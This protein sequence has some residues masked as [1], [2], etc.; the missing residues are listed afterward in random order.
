[1]P[2]VVGYVCLHYGLP[3]LQWA[4]RSVIDDL[5][6]LYVLYSPEGS[7]GHK[8]STPCPDKREDLLAAAQRGA[9][10][11]FEW[12]DAGTFAYEG[13]HRDTIFQVAPN[14]EI[15]VRL[16]YDEIYPTGLLKDILFQVEQTNA[17]RYR[18]PFI[19]FYRSFNTAILHDPAYPII[20][21]VPSRPDSEMTLQTRPVAHMGY[22]IPSELM[23]YKLSIHG[24]KNE[25]R[26]STDEYTASIYLNRERVTDLHP[27]G[28]DFWNIERVDPLD[29]M[30]HWMQD[31]PFYFKDVIE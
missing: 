8:S 20:V 23:R 12:I 9:G 16:D 11:K 24:H 1:M 3:Y 29:Y 22:C 14:A 13:Q 2:K 15:I 17:Q 26:A 5:D 25:L 28:S 19:H 18:I 27:V 4:I 21:T 30:P 7:H 6:R 10:D 31:H